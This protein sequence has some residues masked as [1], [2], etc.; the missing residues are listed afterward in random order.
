MAQRCKC[1]HPVRA[2]HFPETSRPACS[3]PAVPASGV[4]GALKHLEAPSWA[5]KAPESH[6]GSGGLSGVC[7]G[8]EEA[9]LGRRRRGHSRPHGLARSSPGPPGR[10]SA[11]LGGG[12]PAS[13]DPGLQRR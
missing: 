8:L 10:G 12:G 5:A 2:G 3:S 9:E 1:L 4:G 11:V 13:G 7:R 6:G